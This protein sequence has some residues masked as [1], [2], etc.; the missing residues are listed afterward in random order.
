MNNSYTKEESIKIQR[1]LQS[2]LSENE[3]KK[4]EGPSKSKLLH[5][6]L[7]SYSLLYNL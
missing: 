2:K 1:F 5:F 6:Y 7:I 3:I 4:R